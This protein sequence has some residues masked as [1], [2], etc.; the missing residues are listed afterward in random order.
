MIKSRQ[1]GQDIYR[2]CR[3]VRNLENLV[4]LHYLCSWYF[5]QVSILLY[6]IS[7]KC[8]NKLWDNWGA[9]WKESSGS[10]LENRN[11][12]GR[13]DS[14]RWPRD[15]LYPLKLA[16][17]STTSGG[18]SVGIVRLRNKAPKFVFVFYFVVVNRSS[19]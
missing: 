13:G 4:I 7:N 8:F 6:F 9:T 17:T 3:Q 16:L 18:H 12:N 10:G 11:F 19:Q 2:V 15:T 1:D 5:F 14:L